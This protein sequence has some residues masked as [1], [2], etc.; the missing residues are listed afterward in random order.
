MNK[1]IA[2]LA[3][4]SLLASAVAEEKA[5]PPRQPIL[6]KAADGA[7]WSL[8]AK[9]DKEQKAPG[10]RILMQMT[11]TKTPKVRRIVSRWSDGQTTER[12]VVDNLVLGEEPGGKGIQVYDSSQP[13][14]LPSPPPFPNYGISDFPELNW[15]SMGNYAGVGTYLGR[16]CHV[17]Q[18]T[19]SV[20]KNTT[21][22]SEL[23]GVGTAM[24]RAAAAQVQAVDK[25]KPVTPVA[26]ATPAAVAQTPVVQVVET[27]FLD[28]KTQLPVAVADPQVTREYIFSSQMPAEPVLPARFAELVKSTQE[29]LAAPYRKK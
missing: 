19:A 17:F 27:A 5:P 12:W 8:V 22:E 26:T 4:L 11:V 1:L 24:D 25:L 2:L 9:F 15:I 13:W 3:G 18:R 28:V 6:P 29:A 23:K 16:P 10:Y 14:V 21:K 7:E 20:Q